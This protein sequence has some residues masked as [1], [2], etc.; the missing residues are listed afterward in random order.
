MYLEYVHLYII[1]C[2]HFCEN[3][4]DKNLQ[5]RLVRLMCVFLQSLIRNKIIDVQV[6]IKYR[7]ILYNI[8]LYV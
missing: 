6:P 5:T 7:F 4:K 3:I 1:N 2:I 8:V